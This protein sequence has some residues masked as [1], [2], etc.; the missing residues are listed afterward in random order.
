MKSFG[1][2]HRGTGQPKAALT[3]VFGSMCVRAEFRTGRLREEK[4]LPV[5]E[6]PIYIEQKQF[7][8]AGASA[9]VSHAGIVAKAVFF[10][11]ATY[12]RSLGII[13]GGFVFQ[14]ITAEANKIGAD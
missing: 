14:L 6:N 12:G 11:G 1:F 7:D 5:S 9:G 2:H 3:A 4:Q 13:C 8:F 10:L